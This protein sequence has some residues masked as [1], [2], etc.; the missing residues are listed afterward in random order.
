MTFSLNY[1]HFPGSTFRTPRL[2]VGCNNL[3][4]TCCEPS[5]S[6]GVCSVPLECGILLIIRKLLTIFFYIFLQYNILRYELCNVEKSFVKAKRHGI[7]FGISLIK[8]SKSQSV[9]KLWYSLCR[10]LYVQYLKIA[11]DFSSVF[12]V[13]KYFS[14]DMRLLLGPSQHFIMCYFFLFFN[15]NASIVPFTGTWP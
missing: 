13:D 5:N 6:R 3:N 1:S 12:C 2:S 11:D 8:L 14:S 15:H 4:S 9:E 10:N 7:G